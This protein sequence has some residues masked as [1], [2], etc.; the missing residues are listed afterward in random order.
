MMNAS[1]L[2]HRSR[3]EQRKKNAGKKL[4]QVGTFFFIRLPIIFIESERKAASP[5]TITQIITQYVEVK[6]ATNIFGSD[7]E[8][9]GNCHMARLSSNDHISNREGQWPQFLIW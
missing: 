1:I 2:S 5:G 7:S 6:R 9:K 4:L 8:P 3:K